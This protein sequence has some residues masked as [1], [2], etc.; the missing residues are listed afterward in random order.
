MS[1]YTRY[2]QCS[3]GSAEAID[4]GKSVIRL[5]SKTMK[6]LGLVSG[7]FVEI[8]GRKRTAAIVLQYAGEGGIIKMDSLL[9]KNVDAL[10]G[11][12]VNV[13]KA[14]VKPAEKLNI[15]P[16]TEGMTF[17][18][19]LTELF[20]SKFKGIPIVQKN[21]YAFSMFNKTVTFY[22]GS[23]VPPSGVLVITPDT[24]INISSKAVEKTRVSEVTYENIGGLKEEITKIRE[25]IELPMK[26]PQ[27]FEKLGINPPK[28]LLLYGPPGTGKTLLARALANEINAHFTTINGPEIMGKFFG[29]S[30]ENL[31]NI[32]EEAGK[33][34]PAIIFIDEIDAIAPKREDSKGEVERRV[35]SQLLTLMDGLKDRG[36][37]VVIAATNL[38][39]SIDMAL[40]RPGRFDKELEIGVPDARDR[41]EILL[42]HSSKMPLSKEV[43]IKSYALKTHGYSG[44]DLEALCK[45]A[46]MKALRRF[47]PEIQDMEISPQVINKIEVTK[48]DFDAAF[49]EIEPSAMREA[50]VQVTN[51]KWE[52]IGGLD[53]IKQKLKEA[54]EWPMKYKETFDR[55][56]IEGPKGIMLYG[57]PG[58]G[59]TLLAKAVATECE[60]NFLS[61]RGPELISK[62]VG[63]SEKGIRKIFSKARQVAPAVI[64][65]DEID[66]IAPSRGDDNNK[67]VERMV[68]QLLTELDGVEGLE[69][70]VVIAATN[71]PDMID[72][73]L[74]RPGRFD[75][76]IEIGMPDKE[77]RLQILRTSTKKMKLKDVDLEYIADVTEEFSGA[78]LKAL[79]KEAG[80]NAVRQNLTGAEETKMEDFVKALDELKNK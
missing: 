17:S 65:F 62:W 29:Q 23:T 9:R 79:C 33:N 22:V 66:S 13:A 8:V 63:E 57:P 30:E 16:T 44:A 43:D 7:D 80:L 19:D 21:I 28:G 53:D 1:N 48:K 59:K 37:V 35:V 64:F 40:R 45:E 52:D 34:A 5:D 58:C 4:I 73:A 36:K 25:M 51:V 72:K 11:E 20:K 12:K 68:N 18:G 50:I 70:V 71:R 76:V 78:D 27:V 54:V 56:G 3:V 10:L 31:R 49:I 55:V 77:S 69:R 41:E 2:I 6:E 38:P 42:V 60:A 61:V 14:D 46:G 47:L 39:D 67:V 15:S 24:K 75:Y 74:L 26:N 32:F